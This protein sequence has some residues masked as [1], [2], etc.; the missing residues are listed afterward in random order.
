MYK[1]S[2]S[3]NDATYATQANL[4]NLSM[5]LDALTSFLSAHS[6][7]WWQLLLPDI[8]A[9]DGQEAS[10]KVRDRKPKTANQKQGCSLLVCVNFVFFYVRGLI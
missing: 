4:H 6:W 7:A 1:Y 8:E 2:D 10:D 3:Y 5:S 9:Q